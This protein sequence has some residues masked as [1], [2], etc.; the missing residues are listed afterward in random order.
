MPYAYIEFDT[1]ISNPA[2]ITTSEDRSILDIIL[3]KFRRC[4]AKK[5][6][7]GKVTIAYLDDSNS[8]F[9]EDG[10]PATLTGQ[11]GDVMVY[12]PEFWYKGKSVI[13]GY[14]FSF[15]L[16][17]IDD[18][19]KHAPASLVGAYKAY[20]YQNKLYSESGVESTG[21][22]SMTDF[23]SYA[24]ARGE[25]YHIIDYQQHCIIAWMFYAKY[26]TRDSQAV[27]GTGKGV[28]TDLLCGSTNVLGITDTTASSATSN[29]NLHV[30][31]LGIEGAWGY[32]NEWIEGIHSYK[33]DAVIA[34]D[35]EDYH[36]QTYNDIPSSTKRRVFTG[37]YKGGFIQEIVA[38]E[39]MD[40][41]GKTFGFS[42]STYF[43]DS[44]SCDPSYSYIFH[45]SGSSG[46]TDGGVSSLSNN[47]GPSS[48]SDR[49]GSRLAFDG[50]ITVAS[51]VNE[52]ENLP[53]L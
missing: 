9:Y 15:A 6:G 25:G 18:T 11:E 10:T 50:A 7:E 46:S 32:K 17:Q 33:K 3:S 21:G 51:S 53:V 4:L 36:G 1:S 5:T 31:F 44:G 39:H 40:M 12:F 37:S 16:E 28:Y 29:S 2:N 49:T 34:Y 26:L 35:K 22:V 41:C 43:C 48:V 23:S 42:S 38:G 27:C 14:R 52:F 24:R 47:V 45:R 19:W 13:R 8:N 30:N 20:V